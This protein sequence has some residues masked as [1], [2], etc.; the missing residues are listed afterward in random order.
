LISAALL[1]FMFHV[2]LAYS[3]AP[4]A[5]DILSFLM[6]AVVFQ[7]KDEVLCIHVSGRRLAKVRRA[8]CCV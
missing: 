2:D 1:P 7:P 3:K 6:S 8:R 5:F 4:I